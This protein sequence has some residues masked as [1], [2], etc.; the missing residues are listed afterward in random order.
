MA[1]LP[2]SFLTEQEYLKLERAAEYKSEYIDGQIVAMSGA[3]RQHSALSI[4]LI[5]LLRNPVRSKGCTLFNSDVRI[6]IPNGRLYTYPDLSVS[7]EPVFSDGEFDTLLNPV[8]LIEVLSVS[9][10]T[11]DRNQKLRLYKTISSFVEYLLVDQYSVNVE[12]WR[13]QE[14][15]SWNVREI[16]SLDSEF[17]I[18][19]IGCRLAL[20][21]IY[22]DVELPQEQASVAP[23]TGSNA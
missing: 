20:R 3:S 5:A 11:Y 17:V 23:E 9:T 13:R 1:T 19:S 22:D 6:K 7:C 21:D 4:N 10:R 14:D 12:H 18:E 2:K 16:V 8:L 15:G